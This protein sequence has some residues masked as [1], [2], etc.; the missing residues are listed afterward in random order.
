MT[1]A[2]TYNHW[3][4]LVLLVCCGLIIH[5]CEGQ[6]QD[7][8]ALPP[9]AENCN[10]VYISY[11]LLN[12]RKEFPRLKNVTAQ[13]WAFNSTAAILN[14][15]KDVIKAWKL[16]IGFQHDEIL[17]STS[18]GTL[19]DATDFPASVGNGTTLVGSSLPDLDN[20]I[21]TAGDL[22]QIQVLIQ[23]LGTQFGVKPPSVPMPKTI[24]LVNDGY[25]CPQ[26]S[27]RS[28]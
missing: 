28:E 1:S 23:L 15:S 12:R 2:W 9:S 13:A 16:Y 5:V 17:V 24:K 18:G 8:E 3:L 26:P 7:P 14:T 21:N 25:K 4:S 6:G 19:F 11:D 27:T 10:G 20:S 22:T